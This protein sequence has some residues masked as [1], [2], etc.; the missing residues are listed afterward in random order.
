M[1]FDVDKPRT[2]REIARIA[3]ADIA[4]GSPPPDSI[5][6]AAAGSSRSVETSSEIARESIAPTALPVVPA[7]L[8]HRVFKTTP[9]MRKEFVKFLQTIF[10]RLDENKVLAEMDK[11]LNDPNKSD[12][13]IYEHLQQNL[14]QLQKRFGFIRQIWSL[15]VLKSGMGKQANELLHKFDKTQFEDYLEVYDRRYVKTLQK[16]AKLPLNGD[17]I[18]VSDTGDVGIDDRL[19]AGALLSKFP[20]KTHVPLNDKDCKDSSME[21]QKTHKPISEEEVASD[22]IDLIGCLGGLHH[23]PFSR[24]DAF[25]SSLSRVLRPGGVLLFRDHDVWNEDIKAIASMVHTFVNIAGGVSWDVEQKEVRNFISMTRWE[26]LLKRNGITRINRKCLILKDDPTDNGMAIFVKTPKTVDEL[27]SAMQYRPEGL[28]PKQGTRATWLEW[29]NVRSSREYANFIQRHHAYEFDYVGH[30]RQHWQHF[31]HYVKEGLKDPDVSFTDLVFS[32]DMAM[33]LFILA[34]ASI[35]L[36]LSAV[37]SAPSKLLFGTDGRKVTNLSFYERYVAEVEKE[38]SD[39]I[40]ETPFYQFPYLSKIRGLW[41][42]AWLSEQ[43]IF[44]KISNSF[45]AL[46]A[47]IQM[48]ATAAI[49]YPIRKIYTSPSAQEPDRVLVLAKDP[50]GRIYSI[51]FDQV[52]VLYQLPD[53]HKMLS[54]PRYRP[55]TQTIKAMADQKIEICEIGGQ[56]QVTLDL[57]MPR[58]YKVVQTKVIREIYRMNWL[59]D[60]DRRVHITYQIAVDALH[61]ELPHLSSAEIEYIHE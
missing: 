54:V 7:S 22:S 51:Q 20:Y 26:D 52:K 50:N 10:Y 2:V 8:F 5:Q 4:W 11:L 38:Y 15:L 53:G 39:F 6:T 47:T 24:V 23:V 59:H 32:G 35:Q 19:Q 48:V 30:L 21:V 33:N 61:K 9:Q 29:G 28:R 36:G 58:D 1:S 12:K 27:K 34:T 60:S 16:A 31:Y 17:V 25:A 14:G 37:T 55:F 41:K 44:A 46:Y 49:S 3:G 40:V 56:K 42:A 43:S 57:A 45:S 13:E 18:A